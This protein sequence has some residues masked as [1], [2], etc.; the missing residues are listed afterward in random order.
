M[1]LFYTTEN[2]RHALTLPSQPP[3]YNNHNNKPD[4]YEAKKRQCNSPRCIKRLPNIYRFLIR[5]LTIITAAREKVVK[6]QLDIKLN[7]EEGF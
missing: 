5:H 2:L 1:Y 6:D 4:K 3:Q 7:P